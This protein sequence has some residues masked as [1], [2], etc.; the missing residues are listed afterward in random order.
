MTGTFA[1]VT[2]LAGLAGIAAAVT[3][4]ALGVASGTSAADPQ[5]VTGTTFTVPPPTITSA[6]VTL[7]PPT[8]T[9]TTVTLPLPTIT[10]TTF[11]FPSLPSL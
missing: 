2:K 9:S 4:G 1:I 5:K 3:G 10:P 7:P 11:T 8:I 6:T